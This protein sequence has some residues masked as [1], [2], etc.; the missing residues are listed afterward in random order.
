MADKQLHWTL[1]GSFAQ[2]TASLCWI[3]LHAVTAL[4]NSL[5]VI[6]DELKSHIDECNNDEVKS[7]IVLNHA[8]LLKLNESVSFIMPE[9]KRIKK[10]TVYLI[11]LTQNLQKKPT[12]NETKNVHSKTPLMKKYRGPKMLEY[13]I[14]GWTRQEIE[15]KYNSILIPFYLK[16][17]CKEFYGNIIMD[18]NILNVNQINTIGYVLK[19]IFSLTQCKEFYPQKMYDGK[20]DGFEKCNTLCTESIVILK[21]NR[22]HIFAIFD[23]KQNIIGCILK[24]PQSPVSTV[25]MVYNVSENTDNVYGLDVYHFSNNFQPNFK[26]KLSDVVTKRDESVLYSMQDLPD[27][28]NK[29]CLSDYEIFYIH[30]Q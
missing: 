22:G 4:M 16:M 1:R 28:N 13:L 14:F 2:L 26:R 23:V 17:V 15:D 9:S 18:T 7:R 24:S 25:P 12:K 30:N 27:I 6:C 5:Q 29:L 19:S 8:H 20:T 10:S 21:T 11:K 3:N